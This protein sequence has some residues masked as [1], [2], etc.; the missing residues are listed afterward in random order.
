MS[1]QSASADSDDGEDVAEVNAEADQSGDADNLDDSFLSV[2]SNPDLQELVDVVRS[3]YDS[4]MENYEN[5]I[6]QCVHVCYVIVLILLSLKISCSVL[7]SHSHDVHKKN[8]GSFRKIVL[9]PRHQTI[10]ALLILYVLSQFAG[11]V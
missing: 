6:K 7:C 1:E 8:G 5:D 2:L 9:P 3:E 4:I 11:H 10:D